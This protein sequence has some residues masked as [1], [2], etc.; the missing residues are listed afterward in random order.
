M[1][2]F[3]TFKF[4]SE[5]ISSN[6]S[7][8]NSKIICLGV[9]HGKLCLGEFGTPKCGWNWTWKLVKTLLN[10]VN[11]WIAE[12]ILWI[13]WV[14]TMTECTSCF[15]VP[16]PVYSISSSPPILMQI[17]S[18]EHRIP[19]ILTATHLPYRKGLNMQR[20]KVAGSWVHGW[21]LM[22]VSKAWGRKQISHKI[23]L[24]LNFIIIVRDFNMIFVLKIWI[25]LTSS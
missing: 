3:E 21:S 19:C 20:A 9:L 25:P 5:R 2:A 17:K 4:F 23:L 14:V 7:Q 12:T 24:R 10:E 16:D 13:K 22:V 15:L 11:L 18:I 6:W 8:T 1:L